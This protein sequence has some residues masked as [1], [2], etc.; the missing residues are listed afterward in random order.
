[1]KEMLH[2]FLGSHVT[3]MFE[4]GGGFRHDKLR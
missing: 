1:M 4:R 2:S 3:R